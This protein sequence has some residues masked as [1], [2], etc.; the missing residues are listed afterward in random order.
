MLEII[1]LPVE[2]ATGF[3]DPP[4][5]VCFDAIP[6]A[7]ERDRKLRNFGSGSLS[8]GKKVEGNLLRPQGE[9]V[10]LKERPCPAE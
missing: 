1:A 3:D 6:C 10:D 2:E 7:E 8:E 5:S 4:P 9:L